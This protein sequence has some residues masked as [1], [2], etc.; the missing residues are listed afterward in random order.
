M[1]QTLRSGE[2]GA[3]VALLQTQLNTLPR[4]SILLLFLM[5]VGRIRYVTEDERLNTEQDLR[6]DI[7]QQ[8]YDTGILNAMITFQ[9]HVVIALNPST[10]APRR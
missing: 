4:L 8:Q 3:D 7:E 6:L 10:R 2:A 1:P 9:R 5:A